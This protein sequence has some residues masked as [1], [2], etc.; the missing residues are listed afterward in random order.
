[1]PRNQLIRITSNTWPPAIAPV[2]R[3]MPLAIMGRGARS[4]KDNETMWIPSAEDFRLL[5]TMGLVTMA[6]IFGARVIPPLRP[7]ATLIGTVAAAIYILGGLA[8]IVWH[9]LAG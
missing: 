9:A 4:S 8:V 2:K 5:Q 7:H 3:P 6:L 1:M